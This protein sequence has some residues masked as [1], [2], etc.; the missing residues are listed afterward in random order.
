MQKR[1]DLDLLARQHPHYF[2]YFS[3]YEPNV[4]LKDI[5]T[6]VQQSFAQLVTR[7][8][9]ILCHT[10]FPNQLEAISHSH[11][12]TR[13]QTRQKQRNCLSSVIRDSSY[14]QYSCHKCTGTFSNKA[15]L[16]AHMHVH[17]E[18]KMYRC[19]LCPHMG[20]MHCQ[21]IE[22]V[23][24][25]HASKTNIHC[26]EC[27][28]G[29]S[30]FFADTQAYITHLS[31]THKNSLATHLRSLF[32]EDADIPAL[33]EVTPKKQSIKLH[34]LTTLNFGNGLIFSA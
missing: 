11:T 16:H 25:N 33:L 19:R 31:H 32:S 23:L 17:V 3:E 14:Y 29:H 4:V 12:H 15:A 2:V 5:D 26:K 28:L 13:M 1:E 18:K 34:S 24:R 10:T 7:F 20:Q 9:C 27:P 8:T 30:P 21:L 22:H 6:L